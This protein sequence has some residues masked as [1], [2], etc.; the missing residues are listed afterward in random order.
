VYVRSVR[1]ADIDGD[2]DLDIFNADL[3]TTLFRW[4]EN[5][6]QDPPTFTERSFFVPGGVNAIDFAD[7]DAD[8]DL[9]IIV[10]MPGPDQVAWLEN[11]GQSPPGFT[12]RTVAIGTHDEPYLVEAVDLDQDGD[13]DIVANYNEDQAAVWYENDGVQPIPGFTEHDI[14]LRSGYLRG[15]SAGDVDGDSDIDVFFSGFYAFEGGPGTFDDHDG[16]GW[17]ENLGGE[18]PTW[19]KREIVV[20]PSQVTH[21]KVI[22]ADIDND[23]DLDAVSAVYFPG[24][25]EYWEN[26][27]TNPPTWT[28]RF[29]G[30]S[31]ICYD[32]DVQ[33]LDGDG[34]LDVVSQ[35]RDDDTVTWFENDGG[36]GGSRS[37]P[38]WTT[39]VIPTT[40]D[41]PE[42]VGAGDL[43][44]DGLMDLAVG[45]VN[46][47]RVSWHPAVA[48]APPVVCEG[49]IDGDN[50]TD[51]F[52]FAEFLTGFGMMVEPGT[53]GDYDGSGEVD[54]FDFAT[55]LGDF[56]CTPEE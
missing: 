7:I 27:G 5:D 12:V 47:K 52:D 45:W 31:Y 29:I 19:A 53:Q 14:D 23:G 21:F 9:D 36:A 2:S 55:F 35:S 32:L 16:M 25:V 11:D 10:A 4:H 42:A 39:H 24:R 30:L 22:G 20:N 46:T 13:V 33:D 50:D 41:R 8:G 56:G 6:G 37:V 38:A 26:S 28:E 51:V 15:L 17:Y 49:D 40:L 3:G 44:G 43:T 48:P 18:P 34:D 54:V 1:L